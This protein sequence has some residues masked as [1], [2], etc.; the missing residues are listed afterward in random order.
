MPAAKPKSGKPKSGGDARIIDRVCRHLEP[1]YGEPAVVYHDHVN[2]WVHVDVHVVHPS[3]ETGVTTL[4]TTGMSE[5]YMTAPP[6]VPR[7][8]YAR[9]AELLITLPGRWPADHS[10][11]EDP[12][13]FWPYSWLRFLARYPFRNR[14]FLGSGHDVPIEH[15]PAAPV[16]PCPFAGV[17]LRYPR[18][19]GERAVMARTDGPEQ[20]IFLALIPLLSSELAFKREHTSTK[21]LERFAAAGVDPELAD[22]SRA[23]VV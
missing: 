21:L 2:E 4:F 6:R 3:D 17:L 16:V 23:P 8:S 19:L 9:T 22:I 11:L 10:S 15:D 18:K 14:T 12:R 5:R 7:G 13:L 1:H 20:T